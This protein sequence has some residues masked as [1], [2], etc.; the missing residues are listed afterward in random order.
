MRYAAGDK[1]KVYLP[2]Q[3]AVNVIRNQTRLTQHWLGCT[4]GA[5][6][7]RA[8]LCPPPGTRPRES[9]LDQRDVAATADMF[10]SLTV[11]GGTACIPH[12]QLSL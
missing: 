2:A 7:M 12:A 9:N 5:S 10:A 11:G 4:P 3:R 6:D 1:P 8:I